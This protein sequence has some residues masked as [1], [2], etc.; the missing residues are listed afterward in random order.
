MS[1]TGKLSKTYK[2]FTEIATSV[3]SVDKI[4][5]IMRAVEKIFGGYKVDNRKNS[6]AKRAEK[7]SHSR[8]LLCT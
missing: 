5:A 6:T 4:G 7:C 1:K 8:S 2:K 3:L